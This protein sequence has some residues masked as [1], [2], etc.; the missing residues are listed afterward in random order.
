MKKRKTF[1]KLLICLYGGPDTGKSTT[2]REL[3]EILRSKSRIYTEYRKASNSTDY[4][5]LCNV[6]CKYIGIGTYGDLDDQI[7]E[8]IRRFSKKAKGIACQIVVTASRKKIERKKLPFKKVKLNN[9]AIWNV[10]KV[11][12]ASQFK[13]GQQRIA[14]VATVGVV[15]HYL[16]VATR[17]R[18]YED[19][20]FV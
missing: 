8:T 4:H 3:A 15:L 13:S 2:L 12:F 17:M 16:T 9:I 6:F 7:E 11:P 1:R 19:V 14:D 10:P 18:C 5:I 20:D